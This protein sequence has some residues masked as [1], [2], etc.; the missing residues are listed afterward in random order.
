MN[1]KKICWVT[2]DCFLDTDLDYNLMSGLLKEFDIHWFIVFGI[3]NRF[4]EED[5]ASLIRENQ[6]LRVEFV[7][8]RHRG[9]YPQNAMEYYS[10]A[11]RVNNVNA[12][13]NYLNIGCSTPWMLPFFYTVCKEKSIITAHQGCVHEGMGHYRYYNFLRD[14]VYG[15]LKNVNMFSKS[16]ALYFKERYKDARIF[17]LILGLKY[18]GEPTNERPLS[19]D[20]RFLSFGSIIYTKSIETLIDAACILHERGVKGFKISINGT[21]KGWS[22]YQSRIKYPEIF[23]LDIRMINNEE[24]PN[25]FNGAH[26]L[27]Q[28]Y[29]VVSQSGPTKIS[30]CYNL[31]NITSDLPGFTDE[32]IEGITGYS[33]E[34]GNPEALADVMQHAIETHNE[35]YPLMLKGL[36]KFVSENYSPEVIVAKYKNMF[37]TVIN[38]NESK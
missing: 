37:N 6:N 25:L 29:R 32:M 12:D 30:F 1:K 34:K 15:R 17:Q 8:F 18:F 7:Y 14:R 33:F 36:R 11:K 9:R 24:I 28:P 2:P 26:Y 5:F 3:K 22:W 10:L 19:G 20:V 13:V 35:N 21:C 23:E 4:K 31:P 38:Y 16:Q 27:V